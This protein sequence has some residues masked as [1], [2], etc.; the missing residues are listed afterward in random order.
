MNFGKEVEEED[1][2]LSSTVLQQKQP[3]ITFPELFTLFDEG[4]IATSSTVVTTTATPAHYENTTSDSD[5]NDKNN[6]NNNKKKNR[7]SSSNKRSCDTCR[8]RKVKCDSNIQHPC[9]ECKKNEIDCEFLTLPRKRGRRSKE[10]VEVLESRLNVLERLL[11]NKLVR[12]T[13]KGK[14]DS[15]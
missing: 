8:K 6:S 1:S 3:N 11:E 7:S 2:L 5:H 13:T 12:R 9:T 14:H 4:S 15:I 10:Y